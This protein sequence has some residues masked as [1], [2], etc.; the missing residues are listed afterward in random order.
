MSRSVSSFR[1]IAWPPSLMTTFWPWKRLMQGSASTS[2]RALSLASIVIPR[3]SSR[4]VVGIDADVLL[5]Q[6]APPGFGGGIAEAEL[7]VDHDLRLLECRP[8]RGEVDLLAGAAGE[9]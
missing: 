8:D 3:I 5:G 4:C 6:V 7:G 1:S 9:D 2:T